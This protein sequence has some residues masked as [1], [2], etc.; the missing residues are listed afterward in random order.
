MLRHA[1]NLG[2]AQENLPADRSKAGKVN[3]GACI[4]PECLCGKMRS[5]ALVCEAS[6]VRERSSWILVSGF[7]LLA[8]DCRNSDVEPETRNSKPETLAQD[9]HPRNAL[10]PSPSPILM[11][12][13]WVGDRRTVMNSVSYDCVCVVEGTSEVLDSCARGIKIVLKMI[14]PST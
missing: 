3:I 9:S 8:S 2:H 1:E 13:G 10:T 7:K 6:F 12:E 4:T 5:V 11:G 14:L